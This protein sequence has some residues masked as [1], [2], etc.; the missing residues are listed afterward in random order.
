MTVISEVNH[1]DG[2]KPIIR[3]EVNV[4]VP[5]IVMVKMIAR[6][7]EDRK[8]ERSDVVVDPRIGVA[9]VDPKSG[10]AEV[11]PKRDV[12]AN[13]ENEGKILDLCSDS[14]NETIDT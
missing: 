14:S 2:T 1:A 7:I 13:Q 10:D 4:I 9:E 12:A 11:V 6:N 5:E 8:T 3:N